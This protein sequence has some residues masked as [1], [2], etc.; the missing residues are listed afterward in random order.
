[1]I[2]KNLFKNLILVTSIISSIAFVGCTNTLVA[3]NSVP[4]DTLTGNIDVID[5]NDVVTEDTDEVIEVAKADV[6][7]VG[8]IETDIVNE[9]AEEV[10]AE[11][12]AVANDNAKVIKTEKVETTSSKVD[13][14]KVSSTDKTV[15]TA[16]KD[17][18]ATTVVANN[19]SSTTKVVSSVPTSIPTNVP[20]AATTPKPS[21]T[22][23]NTTSGSSTV[24]STTPGAV[25]SGA[26]SSISKSESDGKFRRNGQV[27]DTYEEMAAAAQKEREEWEKGLTVTVTTNN[28]VTD[29]ISDRR[30]SNGQNRLETS[31]ELNEIAK[32]RAE[33]IA[34]D[35]SHNSASGTGTGSE[36]IQGSYGGGQSAQYTV[37]NYDNSVM[38]GA[39]MGDDRNASAGSATATVTDSDGNVVAQ[40]DVTVFDSDGDSGITWEVY[41][42]ISGNGPT[43]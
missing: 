3:D 35:F 43:E 2:R 9:E 31:D 25:A 27:Y 8:V 24:A 30:E 7:A 40:Y 13:T 21:I 28:E 1:M 18:T 20:K 12:K 33:E 38:H 36:I 5:V 42:P 6:E 19:G 32:K 15:T 4:R 16:T 34:S 11:D 41:D 37:N 29:L 10:V 23:T 26:S 17:S 22:T 39:Q 14:N